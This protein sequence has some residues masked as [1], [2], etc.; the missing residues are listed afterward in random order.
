MFKDS[1]SSRI[2]SARAGWISVILHGLLVFLLASISISAQLEDPANRR[3]WAR[4]TPLLWAPRRISA[5]VPKPPRVPKKEIETPRW[6]PSEPPLAKSAPEPLLVAH[7]EAPDPSLSPPPVAIPRFEPPP[8][9]P[10][11][12]AIKTGLLASAA[13]M[14]LP[15]ARRTQR[16]EKAGFSELTPIG[17]GKRRVRDPD[18]LRDSSLG[19]GDFA[20]ASDGGEPRGGSA[21]KAG[22]FAEALRA[23]PSSPHPLEV[24]QTDFGEVRAR[25][26][27]R[28]P[29]PSPERQDVSRA[30]RILS[31]P[32]PAYTEQARRLRLEGEVS[33]RVLFSASGE[34]KVLRIL[35]GLGHGL[36]EK[37]IRAAENITFQPAQQDG[38]S[39]DS[40]ANV[41]VTFQLAY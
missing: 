27:T 24:R 37:A 15:L 10:P 11:K 41:Y 23:G 32:R 40:T 28:G 13:V 25:K 31:K 26:P 18:S 8:I 7:A 17:P 1:V 34:V 29:A 21:V 3:S 5:A 12:P 4:V 38:R 19:F 20:L 2:F 39:V 14:T 22:G 35:K 36:D 16:V 9:Q 30:V 6:Q 33:L